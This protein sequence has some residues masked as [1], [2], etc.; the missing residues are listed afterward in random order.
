MVLPELPQ[1]SSPDGWLTLPPTPV[2]STIPAFGPSSWRLTCAPRALM[3]ANVEAQSA[4]V[5]KLVKREVPSAK[6]ASIP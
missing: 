1:S 4:P 5:E 2:T 3:Q 6:A